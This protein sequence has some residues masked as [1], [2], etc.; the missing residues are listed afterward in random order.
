ME[1]LFYIKCKWNGKYITSHSCNG[2]AHQTKYIS[3][4]GKFTLKKCKIYSPTCYE[5]IEVSGSAL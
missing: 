2:R 5:F 3:K 4:A 1:K